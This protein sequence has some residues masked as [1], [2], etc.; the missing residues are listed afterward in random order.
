MRLFLHM[1]KCA[2]SSIKKLLESNNKDLLILD[3]ESFFTEPKI[4]R[5][6]KILQ[7]LE[8]PEILNTEKIVY[9]HFFPVKYIGNSSPPNLKLVTIIRE[10]IDRLIS[11]YYFWKSGD[12]SSH[13]LW[14]KMKE[15]NWSLT[16]FIL[17]EEMRN[18]YCQYFTKIPIQ[19]FTYIGIYENLNQSVDLCFSNLGL[20]INADL[21]PRENKTRTKKIIKLTDEFVEQARQFHAQD[22]L[23]YNYTLHRF[24]SHIKPTQP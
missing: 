24:H 12:F 19:F 21:L 16:D 4:E 5:D 22:Y 20:N 7:C 1:P 6:K 10:P 2:G 9:G 15:H 13:Y 3:Y 14:R 23:I 18:F 17:C 11:H 8:Q